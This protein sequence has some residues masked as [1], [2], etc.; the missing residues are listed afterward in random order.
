MKRVGDKRVRV[1][2]PARSSRAGWPDSAESGTLF[3]IPGVRPGNQPKQTKKKD[4]PSGWS[5]QRLRDLRVALFFF[6]LVD[7]RKAK[8][9]K[10]I[11]LA[12]AS[13]SGLCPENLQTFKKV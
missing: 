3:L 4:Q 11:P 8:I 12:A 10:G 5:F 1:C 13:V 6:I 9:K 7:F 2:D